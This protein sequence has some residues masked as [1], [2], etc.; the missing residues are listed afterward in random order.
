M[1]ADNGIYILQSLDG[2]RIIHAQAIDNLYW[3]AEC[4]VNPN[5]IEDGLEQDN[6]FHDICKNCN[7]KDPE[8]EKRDELNPKMLL[9][10]FGKCTVYDTQKEV[11][12]EAVNIYEEIMN[13]DIGIIEYG[14]SYIRGWEIK[15]FPNK[16]E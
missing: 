13:D 10:Y 12:E 2:Y 5:I 15:N 3:W 6:F 9:E 8:F 1:S 16:G 7:A 11:L 14:I 4:C